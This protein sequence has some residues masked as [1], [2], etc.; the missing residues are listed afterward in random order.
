MSPG[1]LLVTSIEVLI[2]VD[3]SGLGKRR[4]DVQQVSKMNS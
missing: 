4:D 1:G 3:Q 2:K